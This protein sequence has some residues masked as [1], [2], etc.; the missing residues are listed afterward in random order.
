MRIQ[1][2]AVIISVMAVVIA[3]LLWAVIYFARDEWHLKAQARD[4]DLPVR[5]QVSNKDGFAAVHVSAQGQRASGIVVQELAE[6]TARASAEVYGTVVN[7]Q[8][9]LDLHA[10]YVTA[11]SEARALRAAAAS[12]EAQYRRVKKLFDQDRNA[13]ERAVQAA[14]AQWTTDQAHAAAADQAISAA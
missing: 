5:S 13:S 9:L 6:A 7:I 8:P 3:I 12:S 2:S 1:A 4:D 11:V 10:R 14:Q